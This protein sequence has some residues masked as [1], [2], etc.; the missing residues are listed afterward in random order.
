MASAE[1]NVLLTRTGPG[2]PGGNLMRRYWQPVALQEELPVG[3]APLPVRLLGED[4]V[5][6]RDDAGRPGLLGI[7]CSHRGADLSYGRLEDGGLRCIYHGWLFDVTGHCL[8]QPGEPAGSTFH[9][10]IHHIAYPCSEAGGMILAYLG[11]GEPP[12]LPR[13]EFLEAPAERRA[14][15]KE[16]RECNYLQGNEGNF[17]PQHLG[18]LH[19]VASGETSVSV[20]YY[21]KTPR[22]K[23][24]IEE[25]EFGVRL[26]TILPQENG[27]NYVAIHNFV[28]PSLSAFGSASQD[29][30]GVNWHVPIDDVSHWVYRVQFERHVP[31]D[32][33]RIKRLRAI[34]PDFRRTRVKA[35]RYLQDRDEMKANRSFAGL[36]TSFPEQDACVTEGAGLIQD[37]TQEHLGYNDQCI[38]ASRQVLLRAI[39]TVEQGG[40]APLACW[41]PSENEVPGVVSWTRELPGSVDYRAYTREDERAVIASGRPQPIGR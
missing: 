23:M 11:P 33:E 5:L 34:N 4:L 2:T 26:Y 32:A 30:Y 15:T 41:D 8:E 24:E 19:W 37:R 27:N 40:Q 21:R 12:L 20:E 9:E 22:P 1:E 7:H 29:G 38:F 28:M 39:R 25:T 3:G 10:R 31:I 17:D 35:N 14:T 6:F 13:F 16:L 36:G 18:M